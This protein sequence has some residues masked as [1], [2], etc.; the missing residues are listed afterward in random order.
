ME[1]AFNGI[2]Q[3][4]VG[5]VNLDEGWSWY[6]KYFG[7]DICVF[8]EAA[9]ANL[10][11]NHTENEPRERHAVLALNME[12]GGGFEVWQH[13][14]KTPEPAKFEVQLGDLGI[15]VGKIKTRNIEKA[16]RYFKNEGLQLLGEIQ[17]DPS[18]QQHFF[19][20]DLYQNTWQIIQKSEVLFPQ[21]S[22]TGGIAGATIGVKDLDQSFVVYKE[23]LGYTN[24]IYD[25]EGVFE[26]LSGLS[27][28]GRTYR[29]VLLRQPLTSKGA[30]SDFF[31]PSEIELVQVLS[32]EPKS[33]FE[34]RIWGDPGFIHICFD[35]N[36]MDALRKL[37]KEKGHPFTV[38]SAKAM[39]TFDM[40]EAAGSFS[41][42]Q[43]PEG[44]L[45]EFV[46]TH[47]VPML[48]KIGWYLD[49]RKRGRKP[50]SKWM[51]KLFSLKRV[52]P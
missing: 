27:E 24:V 12:G 25:K 44:T 43:A 9:I 5:V 45:I 29:R 15:C 50:L 21:K 7:M 23:I 40:G 8:E 38:D 47:K 32:H 34:G 17:K 1:I 42:I 33:I 16:Y 14:G 2:Q 18:G 39:D 26:D 31:G 20:K 52:K 49:L 37:V 19:V 11:L 35:M 4:G 6:R 36:G 28:G 10:M 3:L 46:E 30:F 51:L 48:K 13:T 22:V 41:Y